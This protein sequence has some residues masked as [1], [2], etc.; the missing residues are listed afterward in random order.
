MAGICCLL[1]ARDTSAPVRLNIFY[2]NARLFKIVQKVCGKK[3]VPACSV[4]GR[5]TRAGCVYDNA[6]SGLVR[7][8]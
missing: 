6:V 5:G 8:H 1:L 2:F 7:R 4:R 3:A